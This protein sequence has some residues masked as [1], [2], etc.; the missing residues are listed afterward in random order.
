MAR[1]IGIMDA[2]RA[3]LSDRP[4]RRSLSPENA[5]EELRKG[6]G[7]Q[8]EPRLVEIFIELVQGGEEIK[9]RRA[10]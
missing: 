7:S 3:M 4:Y 1:I 9:L 2:Y 8:F 10:G 6:A 5:L